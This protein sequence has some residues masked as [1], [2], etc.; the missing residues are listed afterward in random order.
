MVWIAGC[1]GEAMFGLLEV[2]VEVGME[3]VMKLV[4]WHYR[5]CGGNSNSGVGWLLWQKRCVC[6]VGGDVEERCPEVEVVQW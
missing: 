3:V 4:Y 2:M 1:I 5:G 6:C